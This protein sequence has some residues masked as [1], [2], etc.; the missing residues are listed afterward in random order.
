[1]TTRRSFSLGVAGFALA[2]SMT[3][4][5]RGMTAQE[6]TPEVTDMGNAV[7]ALGIGE[8]GDAAVN[9]VHTSPD[10]PAVDVYLDGEQA[11]TGLAFGEY[12]G[13]LAL[14]AGEHQIQVT[15]EGAELDAAVIDTTVTVEEGWPTRSPPPVSSRRSCTDLPGRPQHAR[16]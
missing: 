6:S 15:A 1:K 3:V 13:W 16:G 9:V 14:P 8:E 2:T 12:S 4:A 5:P 11:L 7:T 10:T